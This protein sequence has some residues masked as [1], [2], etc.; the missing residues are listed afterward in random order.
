VLPLAAQ[1]VFTGNSTISGHQTFGINSIIIFPADYYISPASGTPTAPCSVGSD[2]NNGKTVGAPF[3]TWSHAISVI[4]A[5][6][7][8]GSKPLT[9]AFCQST[10]GNYGTTVTLNGST[11]GTALNTVSWISYPGHSPV[12]SGGTQVTGMVLATTGTCSGI[13]RCYQVTL[14]GGTPYF[15]RLWYNG[16]IRF[17][18][19]LGAA[20]GNLQ[21]AY[22]HSLSQVTGATDCPSSGSN[23]CGMVYCSA[24]TG[25]CQAGPDTSGSIAN[26]ASCSSNPCEITAFSKWT[27]SVV[28][29]STINT[30]THKIILTCAA[31]CGT[32]GGFGGIFQ[33][34]ERYI[35]EN[36]K[37]LLQ[38]AGQW[39]Y[40]KSSR[41]LTYI[42]NPGE[43]PTADLIEIG[44]KTQVITGS[45]LSW[46]IFSGLTLEH[47]NY[48]LPANGFFSQQEDPNL[49]N[50]LFTCDSCSH[51][52]FSNN[53]LRY[54]T[55]SGLH[56]T[57][58]ST[59]NTFQ[60]NELFDI[61]GYGIRIGG[62][63]SISCGGTCTNS[64]TPNNNTVTGNWIW[65]VSRYFPSADNVMGGLANTNT[66]TNN[67]LRYAYD[68]GFEICQ[69]NCSRNTATAGNNL[70]SGNDIGHIGQ[71]VM[72]DLSCIYVATSTST[73]SATGNIMTGNRCH[74]VNGSALQGDPL[75]V[76]THGIYLD[77]QT[78]NWTVTN[79][80]V[81][82]AT[83]NLIH[84]N[85]GPN[86]ASQPNTLRNNILANYGNFPSGSGGCVGI[87]KPT[88]S[89]LSFT[90]QSNI[91]D[92]AT[93]S[94]TLVNQGQGPESTGTTGD[95]N[96]L[97][98]IYFFSGTPRFNVHGVGTSVTFATW[99]ATYGEDLA[100]TISNNPGF[101][102]P[103][104]CPF[105]YDPQNTCDNFTFLNGNTGPGFGF[106]VFPQTF[107]PGS[108]PSPAIPSVLAT[109]PEAV[110]QTTAGC[111]F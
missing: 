74:D 101:T 8:F 6:G 46:T 12:I 110:C 18:P 103:A 41:Q 37:E 58:Q 32:V 94:H 27:A 76:C 40:D 53:I 34:G 69:P 65:Y 84:M 47:D 4:T 35:I 97:S 64:N 80:L 28:I 1:T 93:A 2:A 9:V 54:T 44:N 22:G 85:E 66:Y 86:V 104:A 71:G 49:T 7:L 16:A 60:S 70:I 61:G 107:G 5:A 14:P 102:A 45:G 100:A 82:R 99:K 72:T 23:V 13:A 89:V 19:R 39:Y 77:G 67:D 88:L 20:I 105:P 21:G 48:V 59:F 78:G 33:A 75:D 96:F 108:S 26:W 3:A 43:D 109:F 98:N 73:G 31:Q 95:Q 42:A 63:P 50:A 90:Y 83:C 15:E 30:S 51:V 10:I 68:K 25:T 91:C 87:Q 55:A 81:Y 38:F 111:S 56:F 92:L 11:S 24:V 106:V 79:N 57:G 29:I 17:R 36:V 52:T 62:A